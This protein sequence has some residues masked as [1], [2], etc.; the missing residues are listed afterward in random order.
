MIKYSFI[1]LGVYFLYYAGN[2]V[3][4]L[5]LKKEKILQTDVTEEFSLGDFSPSSTPTQIGIEDVENVNTPNSFLKKEFQSQK[6]VSEDT[7]P[8][9]EDLRRRFESEQDMDD[10]HEEENSQTSLSPEEN[11]ITIAESATWEES[12]PKNEDDVSRKTDWRSL[13]KL[14]ETTVQM[15]ANYDGQKVYHS[16]L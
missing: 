8:E 3:Y 4:D 9:I 7:K 10:E 16:T 6:Q 5:F 13:L 1:L 11:K 12:T 14:S 15:V 2:I